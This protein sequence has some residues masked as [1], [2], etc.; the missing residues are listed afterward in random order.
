MA[1]ART[2]TL[3][4]CGALERDGLTRLAAMAAD[5]LDYA[6]PE[7]VVC[8]LRGAAADA[9]TVVALARLQL[10]A[11]RR[12]C[13]VRLRRPPVELLELLALTGVRHL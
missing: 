11:Q 7:L 8:D 2:V 6:R 4:L 3:A 12:G 13:R 10:A 5:L 9:V 1:A